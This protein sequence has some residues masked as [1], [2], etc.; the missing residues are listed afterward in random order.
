MLIRGWSTRVSQPTGP[1]EIDWANPLTSG[2]GFNLS[3]FLR[4]DAAGDALIT[5][6]ASLAQGTT[7]LGQGLSSAANA[8][9]SAP[10]DLSSTTE[11]TVAFILKRNS[12]TGTQVLVEHTIN[13]NNQAG[14]FLIYTDTT[15]FLASISNGLSGASNFNVASCAAPAVGRTTRV[16][17]TLARRGTSA[18]ACRIWYDG[19]EQVTSQPNT[20]S[21]SGAFANSTT[22]FFG[23]AAT[24]LF[25]NGVVHDLSIW[26]RALADD[27][28]GLWTDSPWR[29]YQSV[30]R[31]VWL[32][33]VAGGGGGVTGSLNATEAGSDAAAFSAASTASGNLAAT[34]TG[35]DTAAIASQVTA[36]GSLAATEVGSDTAAISGGNPA[37]I[38][39]MA[40]QEVGS[41][42]AA[43]SGIAPATGTLTAQ[44]TGTDTA[45]M[46]GASVVAG[47]LAAT[48]VGSDSF[49]ATSGAQQSVGT[50]AVQEVGSDTASAAGAV[51]AQG[52]FAATESGG[53][54][55]I[56]TGEARVMGLFAA[57]ETGQDVFS[58]TSIQLP[59][60]TG[61]MAA[62]ETGSD[63]AALT[64]Q[65]LV[66]GLFT[67][68]EVGSDVFFGSENDLT[69]IR[70]IQATYNTPAID[71]GYNTIEIDPTYW[72]D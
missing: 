31:R 64:G 13:Q 56:M 60:R 15:N 69:R 38:G 6:T 71:A 2:L 45:S 24:S 58:G 50:L 37:A 19:V 48:E 1:V 18:Q 39:S 65:S 30:Q 4:R 59:A 11:I 12:A 68:Q 41:D 66:M 16:V 22:Y 43:I 33:D 49:F 34:E 14:S 62:T 7:T 72:I 46:A 17:V 36:T 55:A 40:A 63:G 5:R 47:S 57:I 29:L 27:D 35:S 61:S 70:P 52:A 26:R 23:R 3:N 28:I 53:D 44:E 20:G 10:L 51:T 54:S 32:S 67:A 8:A 42:T 25:A 21:I 9:F